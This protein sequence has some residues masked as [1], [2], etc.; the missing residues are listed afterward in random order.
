M[1]PS[2]VPP[3]TPPASPVVATSAPGL[4]SDLIPASLPTT[5]SRA[6]SVLGGGPSIGG[7]IA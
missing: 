4:A 5:T 3:S 1:T 2:G 6:A 7:A